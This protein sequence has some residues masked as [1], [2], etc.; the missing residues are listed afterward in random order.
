MIKRYCDVCGFEILR[1]YVSNR[2]K[3]TLDINGR[4]YTADVEVMTNGAA[5]VGDL[6]L[7]CVL[8]IVNE[9]KCS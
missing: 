6:C 8:K 3:S 5:N 1:N 2:L 7:A 9:G 4:K